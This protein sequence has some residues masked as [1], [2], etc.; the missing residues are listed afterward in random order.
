MSSAVGCV[1]IRPILAVALNKGHS[2]QLRAGDPVTF[3]VDRTYEDCF[4]QAHTKGGF[5]KDNITQND[6]EDAY[7]VSVTLQRA[8]E[9]E[10]LTGTG[11]LTKRE[12]EDLE[13]QRTMN[14]QLVFRETEMR[15]T[16]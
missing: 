7:G 16:S 13:G 12:S 6:I 1:L 4:L 2:F 5:E 9:L 15:N 3:K 8:V 14:K 10:S 11:S